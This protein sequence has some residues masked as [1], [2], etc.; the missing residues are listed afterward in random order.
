MEEKNR[1]ARRIQRALDQAP[2]KHKSASRGLR[3]AIKEAM[4]DGNTHKNIANELLDARRGGSSLRHREAFG[5]DGE[6][7][8]GY[9]NDRPWDRD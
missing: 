6:V 8:T 4:E 9:I 7:I 2:D 1:D 3:N 5:D